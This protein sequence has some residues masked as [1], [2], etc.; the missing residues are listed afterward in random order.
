M[1]RVLTSEDRS[2]ATLSASIERPRL[3]ERLAASASYPIVLVIAPAGYGKSVVLRQ[4]LGTLN[5]P[6]VRFALRTEHTTLLGFL[7][8][9]TEALRESA[10]HAIT[11]LAGAYERNTATTKRPSELARWMHAHLESFS[12]VIAIDDM[13]VAEGD[14][15]VAQFVSSLIERTKGSVR[16]ILASRSTTGLPVGT[17]LAYRD[18]DLPI[19]EHDLRFT[20]NEAREAADGVGLSIRDEELSDLLALTEGWPAAMSFALRTSTRSSELRNVSSVTR[21]MIYRLLAEQVYAGLDDDERGLLEVAIALPAIDVSVLER[22]GFDRAFTIVERLRE[23]T[24][25]IYEESPGIYHCHDLFREFLRH[26]TALRGKRSQQIVHERAA[27]A[28]EESGDIEHAIASYVLARSSA[29]VLRLLERDGFDLLERARGDV[30]AHAIEAL[31][32]KTRRENAQLLALQGVVQ[33]I[34]GK[35]ARAE[36]LLRRALARAG[37]N[38]DL[39][40]TTSFRLALLLANQGEDVTELLGTVGEDV[41]QSAARR[42][43]SLS[44]IAA[45]RAVAGDSAAANGALAQAEA[46]MLDIESDTVRAKALHHAGIA[47]HHLGSRHRAFKVL[48][49][50][51]ELAADHHL[52]SLASRA[53][54]VLSNLALHEDDDVVQQLRYAELAAGAATKAGD[55]FALQTALLQMLSARMRQGDVQRSIELEQRLDS[56]RK[57]DLAIRYLTL[58][59]SLRLAWEGRFGEAHRLVSSCWTQLPFNFDRI[60][61][62]SEYALFLALDAKREQAAN[63]TSEIV[64]ALD[65]STVTGLF[66]VR[67]MAIAK[68]LCALVGAV[69]GRMAYA[70]RLLRSVR[71]EDDAVVTLVVRTVDSILLRLHHRGEGGTDRMR[72]ALGDLTAQGYADVARLLEAADRVL[73]YGEAE[74]LSGTKL[75]RSEL[76]VLGLLA[77]GLIPKEIAARSGRSVHTVRVH[78]AN[79]IAKLGCH[80]QSEAVSTARHMGLI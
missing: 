25:F 67:A 15:E 29:D 66:R 13:H 73:S 6:N 14:P 1:V 55:A 58:F 11:A 65:S 2:D 75:T 37:N 80:G 63:L 70:D 54:A 50:S 45:Q 72:E 30:V 60:V 35:F 43:E 64:R 31:D 17:W 41:G 21:E 68:T 8:G 71:A 47:F 39:V 28:L 42:V 20:F 16:W 26:Q 23:R 27:H 48:T 53:N 62:G 38:R 9:L 12:G 77:R 5:E 19:G 49:Q 59:R 36:S 79:V 10:P 33:A 69:S 56:V 34:A 51:A 46:L 74:A 18:A 40:A 78:I 24:A 32:D 4:Y 76:A 7:R 52:Y 3:V 44:L 22:A 57:S 61:C